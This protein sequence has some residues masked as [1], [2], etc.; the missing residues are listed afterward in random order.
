MNFS[1]PTRSDIPAELT[2][3]TPWPT[4]ASICFH[5]AVIA[6]AIS[7][8][9]SFPG[10]I[11]FFISLI[12]VGTRQHALFVVMHEGTHYLISKNRR[13]NDRISDFFAAWPVG[14]STDRYRVRH[15]LHHRYLNTDQDPDW[16]R[17]KSDPTWVLPNSHRGV[18]LAYLPYL[19][20]KGA[21][22]IVYIIRGFGVSKKDLPVAVP[23][24]LVV[25]GLITVA[26]GWKAFALYWL[27]PY[28]TVNPII[29][30]FRYATE[31]MALPWT[32][33]LNS[34]RNIRCS[35]LENFLISPMRGSLH[36][37]HHTY[38][39]IPWHKL[40]KAYD[41]LQGYESFRNHAHEL[42]AYF[43][44]SKKNVYSEFAAGKIMRSE[45]SE[46]KA[47]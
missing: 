1:L 5:W 32:H 47:A 10:L 6:G 44:T 38:P 25:A 29:H 7:L 41:F 43:P 22:E 20:G 16:I 37:V 34:T 40:E 4:L 14:I 19:F 46:K 36:L 45:N 11:T 9:I 13:L 39:Y 28:V 8:A 42:D 23:Y 18:W 21:V 27:I 26:G 31:H 12:C 3:V 2:K 17:K 33:L 24:Y 15:W 35:R 30:R